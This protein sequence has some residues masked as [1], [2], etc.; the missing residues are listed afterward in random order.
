MQPSEPAP[1][2]EKSPAQPIQSEPKKTTEKKSISWSESIANIL[3]RTDSLGIRLLLVFLLGLLLSLTPCIYPMIP[4]TIGILQAQGRKSFWH[5]FSVSLMYT[6]GMATTFALFGL[7]ASCV[8][9]LCGKLLVQ[10]AFIIAFVTLL[11]YFAFSM[12]GF[13]DMYTPRF[14]TQQSNFKGGSFITA[15]IFGA[16]SGT[17]AS[18]CVSPGLALVLTV[19]ATLGSTFLGFLLLFAFGVGL[20]MPLLV[21]GTFSS[22]LN[23]LPSAGMW[24][25]EVKRLFGFMLLGMCFYYLSYVAPFHILMGLVAAT[26]IIVGIFYINS[27]QRSFGF[28]KSF[29]HLLGIG[30]I[31]GSVVVGYYGVTAYLLPP[32][33]YCTTDQ[34]QMSYECAR[35]LA[36]SE[37]KKIF[38]DF[39]ATFCPVCLAINKK[40]LPD[41]T[42]KKSLENY[43]ILKVDGTYDSNE[44]FAT[45]EKKYD[46]KGFPTFLIVD[47]KTETVIERLGAEI[48]DMK[49]TELADTFYKFDQ[50]EPAE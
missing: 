21:V 44:P 15:F 48:Y 22:S 28:W 31:A 26:L 29:N 23:M 1:Q 16:A 37:N 7:L 49:P 12:F 6:F 36:L 19:V 47:P 39:W 2:Q 27:A 13:Y 30:L 34:E 14:L 41:E 4:I 9:P 17:I 25:I 42:V 8:G 10:P 11:G 43:I 45:L 24:M 35:E 32:E 46:I 5:N 20:S 40:V 50:P 3:K 33:S 38:I 18:P